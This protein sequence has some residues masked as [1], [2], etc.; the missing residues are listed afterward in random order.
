MPRA[1]GTPTPSVPHFNT[2]GAA[3]G[4]I[5]LAGAND[6]VEIPQV[7][8]RAL[9]LSLGSDIAAAAPEWHLIA[10]DAALR[11]SPG[12]LVAGSN[13]IVAVIPGVSAISP[14]ARRQ[15]ADGGGGVMLH[16]PLVLPLDGVRWQSTTHLY[17]AVANMGG[18]ATLYLVDYRFVGFV[19]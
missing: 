6:P 7:A 18:A 19:P 12:T 9:V 17:L 1:L 2:W 5:H 3:S 10:E 16:V 14:T 15:Q 13:S 8:S 4:N 11:A